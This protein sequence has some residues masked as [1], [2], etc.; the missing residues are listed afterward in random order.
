MKPG[1]PKEP[2]NKRGHRRHNEQA[3]ALEWR[4]RAIAHAVAANDDNENHKRSERAKDCEGE[5]YVANTMPAATPTTKATTAMMVQA[6]MS[7][8]SCAARS[9]TKCR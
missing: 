7:P 9:K 8:S 3:R 6:I 2:K 1:S 5:H 4:A